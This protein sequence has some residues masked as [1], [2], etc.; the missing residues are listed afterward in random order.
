MTNFIA[1][2]LVVLTGFVLISGS[3]ADDRLAIP[4]VAAGNPNAP[5]KIEFYLSPTCPMCA[6]TFRNTVLPLLGQA[7]KGDQLFV[8]IGIM[9]RSEADVNFARV[10]ACVPQEQLLPFMTHWYF[11]RRTGE[12]QLDKLLQMGKEHGIYGTTVEQCTSNRNDVAFLGFN[13][14]VFVQQGIRQTP[15]IFINKK[16]V[17]DVFYLWQLEE[18]L[19]KIAAR[20]EKE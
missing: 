7:I 6:A 18:L 5:T 13:Q 2:V 20:S 19:P 16:H 4:A 12:P 11:Y 14:L 8:L 1:R 15:A 10:L 17:Q 9:P 3:L